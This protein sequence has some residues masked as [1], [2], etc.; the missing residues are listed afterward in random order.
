MRSRSAPVAVRARKRRVSVPISALISGLATTLRYQSGWLGPPPLV[1]NVATEPPRSW[2]IRGVTCSPPLRAPVVWRSSNGAP[3][4]LPPTRP[5]V[6]RN[7]STISR[8]HGLTFSLMS[9]SSRLIEGS[10][11]IGPGHARDRSPSRS[12]A[13]DGCAH[14]DEDGET[15]HRIRCGGALVERDSGSDDLTPRSGRRWH[16]LGEVR[17][18]RAQ[19]LL[20]APQ[21]RTPLTDP[22]A[23]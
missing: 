17:E 13:R 16:R 6:A 8:F 14:S 4:K 15:E 9:L 1:A 22:R 10:A 5:P 20:T 2:Y 21:P 7:S 19:A 3:L 11:R 18:S 12:A 23:S